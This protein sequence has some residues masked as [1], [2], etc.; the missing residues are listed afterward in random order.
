MDAIQEFFLWLVTLAGVKFIAVHTVINL[1]VAVAA[2]LKDG[3]F[4]AHKLADFLVRKLAPYVLVYGAAKAIGTE[5]NL[6]WLATAAF[7]LIE[8]TL[9]ADLTENLGFLG[10]PL[11]EA[12]EAWVSKSE[13]TEIELVETSDA[14]WNFAE[15]SEQG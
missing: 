8:A 15:P 14:R 4:K 7:A 6:E 9:L 13:V 1:V 2:A 5:A 10:V 11:P 3:Q 12:I